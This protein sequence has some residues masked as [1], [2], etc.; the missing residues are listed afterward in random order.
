MRASRSR[1]VD[2]VARA[3][4]LRQGAG[5]A[6]DR[7]QPAGDREP[8]VGGDAGA[9]LLG[10]V[11]G[12]GRA[13]AL[14]ARAPLGELV[15]EQRLAAD[16]APDE[17]RG[18]DRG[19][20]QQRV[21]RRAR[22]G[23]ARHAGGRH[24]RRRRAAPA[25]CGPP[26]AWRPAAYSTTTSTA[27]VVTKPPASV[28]PSAACAASTSA[29]AAGAPAG[30]RRA[31]T[32]G[33]ASA[34]AAIAPAR[35]A[36]SAPGRAAPRA[37]RRRPARRRGRGG[38]ATAR[39]HRS[40]GCPRRPR[41]PGRTDLLR[42]EEIG[43]A[44][45]PTTIRRTGATVWAMATTTAPAPTPAVRLRLRP[46]ARRAVLTAHIVAGGVGLLGSVAGVLALNVRAATTG[47]PSRRR[48]VRPARDVHAAVR[49]PAQ[50]RRAR[51][52]R[53]ARARLQV[54]ASCGTAGSRRNSCSSSA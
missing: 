21:A 14:A 35:R 46:A 22:G 10:G 31:H 34:G 25:S 54:G 23:I 18:G 20:G 1:A 38:D 37:G 29:T 41:P 43:S 3:Q 26:A 5:V 48:R 7:A 11:A 51:L 4:H 36:S 47:D 12:V 50:P 49:H 9:L 6:G 30:A 45:R 17:Q 16:P 15:P 32:S 52:R 33:A 27:I 28:P 2:V 19:E 24:R 44:P 13:P 40:R 39:R 8:E 53:A 42:A